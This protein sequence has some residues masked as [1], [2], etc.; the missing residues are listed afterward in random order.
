MSGL[1]CRLLAALCL[2]SPAVQA[3]SL[4]LNA[5]LTA[6][7]AGHPALRAP[8]A[9]LEARA[10]ALRQETAPYNP[11]LAVQ[12]GGKSSDTGQGTVLEAT[13]S[14]G[15][16]WPGKRAAQRRLVEPVL[17]ATPWARR[18]AEAR[19]V[20]EAMTSVLVLVEARQHWAFAMDRHEHLEPVQVF[21]RHQTFASPQ[22]RTDRA[23]VEARL[24][25]LAAQRAR[26]KAELNAAGEAV[27]AWAGGAELAWDL[28]SA[29]ELAPIPDVDTI[30]ASNPALALARL[31]L[32]G[33]EAQVAYAATQGF[34]DPEM[35]LGYE[36][37][38][39]GLIEQTF[40]GGL[41]LPL[42]LLDTNR[43]GREAAER[44][45]SAV[46][47]KTAAL[48]VS[49]RREATALRQRLQSLREAAA[50]YPGG[51]V[52]ALEKGLKEAEREFKVG[53]LALLSYLEY[54]AEAAETRESLLGLG[55]EQARVLVE[56]HGLAGGVDAPAALM[57]MEAGHA[58]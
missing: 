28:P 56:L 33:A 49:L 6:V 35:S 53:R 51:T 2:V 13:L 40:R 36:R 22:Q 9:E 57:T 7:K 29:L 41:S 24:Q 5:Y 14:Q 42:P 32:A 30:V 58:E 31:E 37:E 47:A 52:L 45:R 21:L 3:A 54:E 55:L 38:E 27:R 39:L 19:L 16:A 4:D 25:N 46:A 17:A 12:G 18:A 44:G 50:I 8:E 23:V 11:S 10:A 48:E 15:F 20:R 1:S 26:V 43:A 34:P